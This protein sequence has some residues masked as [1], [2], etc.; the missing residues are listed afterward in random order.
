M[1]RR[2]L[3]PF[4]LL[5]FLAA[6]CGFACGGEREEAPRTS[7]STS[8]TL[9]RGVLDRVSKLT[10]QVHE[11][12]VTCDLA[13]GLVDYPEGVGAAKELAKRDLG[14]DNC[15]PNVKFCGDFSIDKSDTVRTFAATAK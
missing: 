7:I 10:L 9:P 5:C 11:G 6:A 1:T 12:K 8:F 3:L 13:T 2:G 15:P 14:K 4:G